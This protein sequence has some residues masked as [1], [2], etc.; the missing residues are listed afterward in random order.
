MADYW[1]N[2]RS[3]TSTNT[4]DCFRGDRKFTG[5]NGNDR[6]W[7]TADS[8]GKYMPGRNAP[9]LG[10][11]KAKRPIPEAVVRSSPVKNAIEWPS[12]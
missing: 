3:Y 8:K 2:S 7:W 5:V 12:A 11:K 9:N 10:H 4:I 1:A 6:L